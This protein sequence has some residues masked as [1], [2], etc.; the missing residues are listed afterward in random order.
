M[1]GS[2][3][4]IY[5]IGS[6]GIWMSSPLFPFLYII[7]YN[8]IVGRKFAAIIINDD[9]QGSEDK[10]AMYEG[11]HRPRATKRGGRQTESVRCSSSVDGLLFWK[12]DE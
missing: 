3:I 6:S 7:T 11:F 9:L 12:S 10:Y 2:D 8:G 4:T 1:K 5:L